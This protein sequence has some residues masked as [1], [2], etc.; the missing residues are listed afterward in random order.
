MPLFAHSQFI[1]PF[2]LYSEGSIIVTGAEVAR[3]NQTFAYSMED[4]PFYDEPHQNL[5][6]VVNQSSISTGF[7]WRRAKTSTVIPFVESILDEG[8]VQII[9]VAPTVSTPFTSIRDL[10]TIFLID[11]YGSVYIVATFYGQIGSGATAIKGYYYQ[12]YKWGVSGVSLLSTVPLSLGVEYGRISLD[13]HRLYAAAMVWEESGILKLKGVSINPSGGLSF[14]PDVTLLDSYSGH[15]PDIAMAHP[16]IGPSAGNLIARIVYVDQAT[17][18]PTVGYINY[19]DL[20]SGIPAFI[21]DDI[22]PDPFSSP[23]INYVPSSP[24]SY[25]QGENLKIDCPDH[26]NYDN[27]AYVYT[28][29]QQRVKIRGRLNTFPVI[30]KN[31]TTSFPYDLETGTMNGQLA[32]HYNQ[33]DKIYTGWRTNYSLFT[34]YYKFI[35]K[36]TNM[37]PAP[38]SGEYYIINNDI[39]AFT[40][41]AFSK[42]DDRATNL[43]ASYAYGVLPYYP[44][45]DIK[46]KLKPFYDGEFFVESK[47]IEKIELNIY[48]NPIIN[49]INLNYMGDRN[50]LYE[51]TINSIDGKIIFNETGIMQDLQTSLNNKF[52]KV[53]SGTYIFRFK[54]NSN[55]F[56]KIFKI[57]KL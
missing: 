53:T 17:L 56:E 44:Y 35:G 28:T 11:G 52:L 33:N 30:T 55:N 32:I 27:W 14:G 21:I 4:V 51:L 34:P 43:F 45:F 40:A 47:E 57:I 24:L 48:P 6:L 2:S 1:T 23:F 3:P 18:Y 31:I 26:S 15:I 10:S 8:N 13:A 46:Y 42:Q 9:G 16:D 19:F 41:I 22:N 29:D 49:E 37:S 20:I 25:Y 50:A 12:I 36:M 7:Y 54:G 5:Y 39:Y 38:I